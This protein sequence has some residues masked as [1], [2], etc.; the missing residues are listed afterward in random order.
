VAAWNLVGVPAHLLERGAGSL[1]G[2]LWNLPMAEG[3]GRDAALAVLERAGVRGTLAAQPS[4]RL[5]HVLTHR[6]LTVEVW[7][8]NGAS[9]RADG[10]LRAVRL[11]ELSAVGVSRLTHKALAA[12]VTR[13]ASSDASRGKRR[14]RA[15]RGA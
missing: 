13:V 12:V 2:G 5:E 11:D 3:S 14:T 1:F 15:S 10:D 4:A 6:K 9:A 8:V 7:E